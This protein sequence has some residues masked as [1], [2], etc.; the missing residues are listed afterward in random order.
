MD[1]VDYA[2][3]GGLP[4]AAFGIPRRLHPGQSLRG[5][6]RE[7]VE[8]VDE[9]RRILCESGVEGEAEDVHVAAQA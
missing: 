8:Y 6:G 5:R 1:A 3:V 9:A 2:S 7:R 4:L